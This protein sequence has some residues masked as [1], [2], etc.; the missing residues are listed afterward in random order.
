[1]RYQ[2]KQWTSEGK[3]LTAPSHDCPFVVRLFT[4]HKKLHEIYDTRLDLKVG[5]SINYLEARKI[6]LKKWREDHD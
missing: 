6:L 5:E 3:L 4:G 2:W 1:V